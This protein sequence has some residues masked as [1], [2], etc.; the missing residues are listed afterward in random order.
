M[1]N[2]AFVAGSVAIF[3]WRM[4]SARSVGE[5][6]GKQLVAYKNVK[7]SSPVNAPLAINVIWFLVRYLHEP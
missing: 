6:M 4:K 3:L 2:G 5:E 7:L 1:L